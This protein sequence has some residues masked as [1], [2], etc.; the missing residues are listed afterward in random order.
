MSKL[1]HVLLGT[2]TST[3]VHSVPAMQ[4]HVCRRALLDVDEAA[5]GTCKSFFFLTLPS[6]V[7]LVTFV[8]EPQDV[9]IPGVEEGQSLPPGRARKCPSCSSISPPWLAPSMASDHPD[10]FG[11]L[12]LPTPSSQQRSCV[13]VPSPASH[14]WSQ[15]ASEHRAARST[16]QSSPP[17]ASVALTRPPVDHGHCMPYLQNGSGLV[18]PRLALA[19]TLVIMDG[20]LSLPI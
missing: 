6:L 10:F 7:G 19:I 16:E 18:L 11:N 14:Q 4:R 9:M 12:R 5:A 8:R 20:V 17:A 2:Y 3:T 1:A 15:T 13:P